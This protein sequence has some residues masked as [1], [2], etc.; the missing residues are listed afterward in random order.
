MAQIDA[1]NAIYTKLTAVQTSGTF[2]EAVGGRIWL[3]QAKQDE[4]FPFAVYSTSADVPY[5]YFTAPDDVELLFQMDLYADASTSTPEALI[6]INDKLLTLLDRAA[7]T[8]TGHVEAKVRVMDRGIVTREEDAH[9]VTSQW[10]LTATPT[11]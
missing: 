5:K 6:A 7:I 8:M 3:E 1:Y 10:R 4:A 9:R 2:Y 11:A